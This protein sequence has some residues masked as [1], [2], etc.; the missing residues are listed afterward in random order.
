MKNIDRQIMK[1]IDS[2]LYSQ[3]MIQFYLI[4]KTQL[5]NNI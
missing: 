5:K 3:L 1:K 2:Q 4:I